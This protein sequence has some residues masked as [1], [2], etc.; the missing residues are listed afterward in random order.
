MFTAFISTHDLAQALVRYY[1]GRGFKRLALI[2]S[3]DA[4]GQDGRLGFEEAMRRPENAEVLERSLFLN[5]LIERKAISWTKL[6][7]DLQGVVPPTVRLVSVRLPEVDNQNQVLL[8]MVVSAKEVAPVLDLFRK[9][10]SSP[11]FGPTTL[12]NTLPPSQ[13]DPYFRYHVTVSYAQ[14]L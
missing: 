14:K 8:D 6:F 11:Q 1:R 3:T 7:H 2:T 5:T 4:S 12:V 9:F 13:T 10:E